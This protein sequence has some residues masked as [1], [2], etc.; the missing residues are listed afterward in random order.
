M[1]GVGG[2][3]NVAS[4]CTGL[5][6]YKYYFF[7]LCTRCILTL[8]YDTS[9]LF[10]S[11]SKTY[12][13]IIEY[14]RAFFLEILQF[15][16]SQTGQH[17]CVP[18]RC[19]LHDRTGH[20]LTEHV[21]NPSYNTNKTGFKWN[22]CCKFLGLLFSVWRK[23]HRILLVVFSRIDFISLRGKSLY[24]R[25]EEETCAQL[26]IVPTKFI[27]IGI[28][29]NLGKE[30][31]FRFNFNATKWIYLIFIQLGIFVTKPSGHW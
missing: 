11:P 15:L 28:P 8:F 27:V 6:M 31:L 12:K 14:F 10:V 23:N 5:Y 13:K 7:W 9:Q 25:G 22:P 30:N 16:P 1:L 3:Q 19:F 29:T 24:R 4:V 17:D 20:D 18:F 21:T 2:Q 26:K